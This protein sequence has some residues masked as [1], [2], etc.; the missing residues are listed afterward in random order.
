MLT[1]SILILTVLFV[2]YVVADADA[3]VS[4]KKQDDFQRINKYE[5]VELDFDSENEI[6]SFYYSGESY[7][8]YLSKNKDLI[9]SN[10]K[11]TINGKLNDLDLNIIGTEESCHYHI[12][13]GDNNDGSKIGNYESAYGVISKCSEYGIKGFISFNGNN[14]NKNYKTSDTTS[15]TRS[16]CAICQSHLSYY[17]PFRYVFIHDPYFNVYINV[18]Y[19]CR[20]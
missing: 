17:V 10:I 15:S 19:L 7:E 3:R 12:F 18:Y 20:H 4:L 6:L 13:G 14:D 9:L 11:H 8:L 2:S 1:F 5:L 16:S